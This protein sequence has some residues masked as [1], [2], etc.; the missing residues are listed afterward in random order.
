VWSDSVSKFGWELSGRGSRSLTFHV[1]RSCSCG[2]RPACPCCGSCGAAA[3]AQFHPSD[4]HGCPSYPAP[5]SQIYTG[6]YILNTG[7]SDRWYLTK[8]GLWIRIGFGFSDFVDPDSWA[9]KLRNFSS[10]NALFSY[11]SK[12]KFTAKKVPVCFIWFDSNFD[13]KKKLRNKLSS[14]VLF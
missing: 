9:R 3:P 10:K 12:K 6:T 1:L 8:A 5:A 4:R 13:F 14:K 7:T 2:C 11:F